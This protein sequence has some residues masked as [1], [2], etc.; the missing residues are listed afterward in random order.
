M[1][2]AFPFPAQAIPTTTSK[3]LGTTNYYTIIPI[4]MHRGH[5]AHTQINL[6][7]TALVYLQRVDERPPQSKRV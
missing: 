3:F 6:I 4:M 5:Y 2:W 7:A 1:T